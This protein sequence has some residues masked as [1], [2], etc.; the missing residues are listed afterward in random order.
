MPNVSVTISKEH[1]KFFNVSVLI[2]KEHKTFFDANHYNVSEYIRAAI[3]A[4]EPF[5][6]WRIN[7][8][9]NGCG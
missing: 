5:K 6:L 9:K 2:S 4:S 7:K 8:L 1:K 3:D